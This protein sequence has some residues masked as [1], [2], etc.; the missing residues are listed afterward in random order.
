[1]RDLLWAHELST[2]RKEHTAKPRNT[3]EW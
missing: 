3:K 1:M 2:S